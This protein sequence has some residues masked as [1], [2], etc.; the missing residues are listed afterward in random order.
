MP[1]AAAWGGPRDVAG[2]TSDKP[3]TVAEATL[4]GTRSGLTRR[5][6]IVEDLAG[7]ATAARPRLPTIEARAPSHGD[8]RGERQ[9]SPPW[10]SDANAAVVFDAT[11][12]NDTPARPVVEGARR[13]GP[14]RR[15]PDAPGAGPSTTGCCG[16]TPIRVAATV[17]ACR[18]I[19]KQFSRGAVFWQVRPVC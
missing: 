1:T 8:G 7:R 3:L 5:R 12:T 11:G 4:R 18:S 2:S 15:A 13:V 17:S 16:L 14:T 19:L 10:S 9:G 6:G